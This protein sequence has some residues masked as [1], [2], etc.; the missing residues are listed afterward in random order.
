MKKTLLIITALLIFLSSFLCACGDQSE[1]SSSQPQSVDSSAPQEESKETSE[2]DLPEDAVRLL[3]TRYTE[4]K[5][6]FVMIGTCAEGAE[7]TAQLGDESITVPSYHGW[8]SASFTKK[9]A[10]HK[11]TFTQT[12]NGEAYDIPRTYNAIPQTSSLAGEQKV[13]ASNTEFQFFLSKMIPDFEGGNLYNKTT[14]RSMANRVSSHLDTM[15]QYN[16]DAEI[17][18]MVIPSPMT[19]YPEL[20]PDTY[21]YNEGE[22]RLDQVTNALTEAGATVIDV[23]DTFKAHKNDEMPLYYKLDSH[24]ADYGAYLAYTELF[25][26]IS[27]KFPEAAPR[28]IDD[29]DWVTDDYKSA[30]VI[31]YLDIDQDDVTEYGYYRNFKESI[32][33]P[34]QILQIP[35]YRLPQLLYS[36]DCTAKITFDTNRDSLPSCTVYRDSYC[37]AIFDLI[38]ERMDVTNYVGMWN[39]AWSNSNIQ[40]EQPDYVIYIIAEWNLDEVVYR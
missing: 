8:F 31:M 35:R 32:D 1:D 36:D 11:V 40:K 16:P 30:D 23:R 2:D 38:P 24:W 28:A 10:L 33:V 18:Y 29:F 20:V 22:T 5:P 19:I 37:A 21:K 14:L 39:Y 4:S 7:V 26:H 34:E 9:G 17:I 13:I 6:T 15:H 12:V 3:F 25:N 27:Q